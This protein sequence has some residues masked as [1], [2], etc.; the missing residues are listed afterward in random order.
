MIGNPPFADVRL[1]YHGLQLALHDFF[2]AKSLNLRFKAGGIL[3][4]VTSHFSLDKQ[5][6]GLRESLAEQANFLDA[7]RLPSD[8][9]QAGRRSSPTACS[10]ASGAGR[11]AHHADP[12]VEYSPVL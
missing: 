3:A 8:A 12:A 11:T 9:L 10:S 6:A 4:L 7:I 5:N 1:D 2:L